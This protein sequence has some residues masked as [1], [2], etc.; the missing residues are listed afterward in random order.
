MS[1]PR[2]RV[3]AR[4]RA[5]GPLVGVATTSHLSLPCPHAANRRAKVKA[6][7]SAV[8]AALARMPAREEPA[9]DKEDPDRDDYCDER[10]AVRKCEK[11]LDKESAQRT[12]PTAPANPK[13][14]PSVPSPPECPTRPGV[15]RSREAQAEVGEDERRRVSSSLT[16]H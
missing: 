16:A 12:P 14:S 13:R 10:K 11:T 8:T 5:R 1:G 4:P 7:Q 6:A 3:P 9:F 2:A 15:P